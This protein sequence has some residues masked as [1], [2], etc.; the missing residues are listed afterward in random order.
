[1]VG[2]VVNVTVVP[3][4]TGFADGETETLTGRSGF[5]VIVTVLDVAGLLLAQEILEVRTHFTRSLLAGEYV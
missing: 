3:A 4:R 2:V 5:A 1:M